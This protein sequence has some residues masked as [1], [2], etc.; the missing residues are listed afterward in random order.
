VDPTEPPSR[1]PESIFSFSPAERPRNVA[2]N[3]KA[4]YDKNHRWLECWKSTG[5]RQAAADAIELR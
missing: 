3:V 2:D 5:W 4:F 1:D